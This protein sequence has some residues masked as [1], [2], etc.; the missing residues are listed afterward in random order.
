MVHLRFQ[1]SKQL[2]LVAQI[3][4][5][6]Q[7]LKNRPE[8]SGRSVISARGELGHLAQPNCR[9]KKKKKPRA[10]TDVSGGAAPKEPRKARNRKNGECSDTP[11]MIW[12][13]RPP[14][15]GQHQQGRNHRNKEKNMIQ[16]HN[17]CYRSTRIVER[18]A[19]N[20]ER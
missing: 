12:R 9:K 14:C 3:V 17:E 10:A 7:N 15:L 8:F 4:R 20:V 11:A 2:D 19:L 6:M 1:L 18:L 16:I 5:G 13:A